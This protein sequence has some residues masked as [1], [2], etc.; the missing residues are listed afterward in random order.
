MAKKSKKLR[1]GVLKGIVYV[2]ASFNNTM[3]TVTDTNGEAIC[4]DSAGTV[5]FKGARKSTPLKPTSL[6]T[7]P[8]DM[9][10][11]TSMASVQSTPMTSLPSAASIR[12][13][14]RAIWTTTRFHRS[15]R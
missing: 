14:G 15:T 13:L 10:F 3:V 12:R 1:K 4:W 7:N 6:R 5:G 2:K 11:G 9:R 8:S